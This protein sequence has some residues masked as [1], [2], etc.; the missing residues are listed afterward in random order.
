M[1]DLKFRNFCPAEDATKSLLR[2]FLK[3]L[4]GSGKKITVTSVYPK[5]N[6]ATGLKSRFIQKFSDLDARNERRLFNTYQIVEP[7]ENAEINIWYSGENIRPPISGYDFSLSYDATDEVLKNIYFPFWVT[8]GG[9][10]IDDC[11]NYQDSLRKRRIGIGPRPNSI[12]AL[13][14]NPHPTRLRILKVLGEKYQVDC[15]GSVFGKV[16]HDKAELLTRYRYN[17]CFENDLYPGYVSEKPFDSWLAGSIPI[18]WG[19]DRGDFINPEAIINFASR[20]TS[21]LMERIAK[22]NGNPKE[23]RRMIEVPILQKKYD[24][25]QLQEQILDWSSK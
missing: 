10:T 25:R 21:E 5:R 16:V 11:L 6:L 9:P 19:I 18:W 14:G 2:D 7:D 3:P 13:V 23:V 22:I 20:T 8:Q 4:S 24:L 15:F 12:C 17:L 1:N